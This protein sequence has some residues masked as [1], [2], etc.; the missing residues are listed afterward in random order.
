MSIWPLCVRCSNEV[1]PE[2]CSELCEACRADVAS[3]VDAERA[4]DFQ[5]LSHEALV[6]RVVVKAR[7]RAKRLTPTVY[8]KV[9]S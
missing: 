6:T 9:A 3:A 1:S 8:S 7:A 4:L 5:A 2:A